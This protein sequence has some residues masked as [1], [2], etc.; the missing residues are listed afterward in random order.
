MPSQCNEHKANAAVGLKVESSHE[1][2]TS[3]ITVMQYEQATKQRRRPP[4]LASCG[5]NSQACGWSSTC[6]FLVVMCTAYL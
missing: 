3:T 6:F 4:S 1:A 5:A 2:R